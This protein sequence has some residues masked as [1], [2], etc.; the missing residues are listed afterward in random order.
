MPT[1]KKRG[2]A[3]TKQPG[4]EIVTLAHT[5]SDALTKY[6]QPIA[7]A[8]AVVA[9]VAVLVVGYKIVQ[10]G[11][12]QKAAPLVT[13]AYDY[14][15]P[16]TGAAPDYAR[17][18]EMFRDVS[19]KYSGTM[20]A[21]IAGYYAGNCLMYLGKTDE[22]VKEYEQVIHSSSD[23]KFILGLVYQRLGYAYESQGKRNEAV[24]AFEQSETLLG[25][26]VATVELAKL[27]EKA[28]NQPEAEKKYKTVLEKLAGTSW[29]MDAMGKVQ[30]IA[31]SPQPAAAKKAK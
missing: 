2:K 7:I 5:I 21:S 3:A 12:E 29:G 13:A 14:Y 19:N 30:K 10:S 1:I 6:R 20:A 9:A 25:P 31:P 24:K 15:N 28:G 27:Y 16:A 4:Q 17:A 18:L 26:G 22:A 11:K 8:L 23:R